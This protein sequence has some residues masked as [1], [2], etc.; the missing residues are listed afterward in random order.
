MPHAPL[1]PLHQGHPQSGER[2]LPGGQQA[3]DAS[4]HYHNSFRHQGLH[5]HT[6]V[7]EK[8]V[9]RLIPQLIEATGKIR[10]DTTVAE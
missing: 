5:D 6:G 8:S 2:Q 9:I 4:A 3:D 10:R 7:A 1:A